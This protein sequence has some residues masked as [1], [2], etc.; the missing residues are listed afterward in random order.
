MVNS[1]FFIKYAINKCFL[2]KKYFKKMPEIFYCHLSKNRKYKK[3]IDK[4][5]EKDIE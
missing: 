5:G 3:H 1:I 2:A 4:N